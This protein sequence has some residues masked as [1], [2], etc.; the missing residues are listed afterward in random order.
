MTKFIIDTTGQTFGELGE[1]VPNSRLRVGDIVT[2][3]ALSDGFGT[4]VVVKDDDCYSLFGWLGVDITTAEARGYYK[5]GNI[6]TPAGKVD[7]ALLAYS[8]EGEL[9][10]REMAVKKLTVAEIEELLGYKV[11]I[12]DNQKESVTVPSEELEGDIEAEEEAEEDVTSQSTPKEKLNAVLREIEKELKENGVECDCEVCTLRK[13]EGMKKPLAF[14]P[15]FLL[16][17]LL[18]GLKKKE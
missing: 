14:R 4:A 17:G 5:I 18:D 7:D 2:W 1:K 15:E 9:A 8:S 16:L 10:I 6:V 3:K 11:E 13:Q 12:V